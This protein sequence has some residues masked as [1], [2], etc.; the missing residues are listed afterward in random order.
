MVV[1]LEQSLALSIRRKSNTDGLALQAMNTISRPHS[2]K[3]FLSPHEINLLQT[4]FQ[5]EN[6]DRRGNN[7]SKML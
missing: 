3:R 1:T 6:K 2:L 7:T 4:S 5:R